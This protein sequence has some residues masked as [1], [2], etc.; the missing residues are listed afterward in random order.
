MS[1]STQATLAPPSSLRPDALLTHRGPFVLLMLVVFGLGAV[2]VF[3]GMLNHDV[4]W[5]LYAAERLVDGARLGVDVVEVNPPLVIW[6]DIPPVLLA[7]VAGMSDILTFRLMVL[8]MIAGSLPLSA[9]VLRR[10]W[11]EQPAARH[12]LLLLQLFLVLPMVGYDF[13]QREHLLIAL[14]LPYLF[15]A[16]ARASGRPLDGWMPWLI[17]AWAAIGIALKPYFLPAWLGV[18]AYLAWSRR[19]DKP[20]FRPEAIAVVVLGI[21]YAAAVV[22]LTPEYFE[23]ARKTGKVYAGYY[24]KPFVELLTELDTLLTGFAL[25][26]FWL[27]RPRG[28]SRTLCTIA[29][30]ANVALL[31]GAF[32][33]RKGW[34]Y[35]FYPAHAMVLLALALL[36][37]EAL[38]SG[39]PESRTVG[40]VLGLA[41][42]AAL[43]V[44]PVKLALFVRESR[45]SIATAP[46]QEPAT[47]RGQLIRMMREQGGR[48]GVYVMSDFLPDAF[49]LVN[50]SGARW[51]CRF[52]SLWMLPGLYPDSEGGDAVR[53][54]P[55]DRLEPA[56]RYL[57]DSV[58][59]DL[60]REPP[61]LLIVDATPKKPRFGGRRFDYV[62]YFS[63]D[64]RFASLMRGYEP[65]AALG[66]FQIY[67]RRPD[68][69][70]L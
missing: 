16:A 31:L 6:L 59:G 51:A 29:L 33:Q 65:V 30:I 61:A 11:P 10:L 23:L 17:G 32:A 67:R 45:L 66:E 63:R 56:E 42:L 62:A 49:P 68:L 24:N 8:A 22:A 50:Y 2:P 58:V 25:L 5:M 54:H 57:N 26:G 60:C 9:W 47:V 12:G 38:G 13:G 69:S 48:G 14:L 35:H 28:L 34:P 27:I 37:F 21:V 36:V 40:R 52:P 15:A 1:E 53:F 70:A 46:G 3:L 41:L 64:P 18:E 39:R 7:R 44:V 20:W 19:G 55:S 4:S 43:L